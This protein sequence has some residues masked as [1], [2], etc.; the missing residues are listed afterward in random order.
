MTDAPVRVVVTDA[1]VLINLIHVGR[2]D[3]LSALGEY[4]F[5]VTE[6]VVEEVTR[7]EQRA[8]LLAAI[9]RDTLRVEPLTEVREIELYADLSGRLGRGEAACLAL[10]CMR[11]WLVA[12]DEKGRF[13]REAEARLGVDG[14]LTTPGLFVLAIRRRLLTVEQADEAKALL[15]R[16]RFRMAFASFRD[17]IGPL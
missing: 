12:S 6:H 11:G 14:I 7:A 2:L 8:V 3:M 13:R 17:V 10:A 4:E 9:E 1:N 15:E 5:I 16:H